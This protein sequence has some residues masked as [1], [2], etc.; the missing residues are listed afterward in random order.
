MKHVS[1]E[2]KR[3][4]THVSVEDLA[5]KNPSWNPISSA[6]N[7]LRLMKASKRDGGELSRTSSR[8]FIVLECEDVFCNRVSTN[9]YKEQKWMPSWYKPSI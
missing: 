9:L 6:M 2:G 8:A 7:D 3:Y 4:R 5:Y 1:R